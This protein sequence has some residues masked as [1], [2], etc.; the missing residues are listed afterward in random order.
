MNFIN[1]LFDGSFMPHGHCLKWQGDLLFMHFFGDLLTA[2]AYFLIPLALIH[3][4]R[5]RND[6]AFNWIFMMAAAFIFLCGVTHFMAIINIWH[7]YYYLS[8]IAKLATGIVSIMTTI[9]IWYLLPRIIAIPSNQEFKVKNEQ[10]LLTQQKLI[11]SNQ[12]LEERVRARTVE[13]EKLARTDAL[14]GIMNRGGLMNGLTNEMDRASRYKH[15]LTIMMIDID[16]FKQVNDEYGHVQGDN[17]IIEVA[18]ILSKVSRSTDSVGR[19]G[20]EEFLL[21]MPETETVKAKILA[22]RIRV[23]VANHHFCH[24]EGLDISVTC[25]IGVTEFESNQD[26][27]SLL[28]TV[29]EM[30]YKAKNSGRNKIIVNNNIAS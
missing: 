8:G 27:S 11:E 25:S 7:G 22:E 17:V 6:L 29:D 14:T 13:L 4:F 26:S 21:L 9:M 20:G 28:K 18:D 23:D 2:T 10:L 5:K 1:A 24:E 12:L 15:P 30:L 19:Y 16:H 3:L